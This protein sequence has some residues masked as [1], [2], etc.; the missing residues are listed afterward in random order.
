MQVIIYRP[1]KNAMQS[2]TAKT[3]QWK[4][5]FEQTAPQFVEPVMG[6]VGMRDTQQELSLMFDTEEAAIAYA[7]KHGYLYTIKQPK[8]RKIS[9]KNYAGN[10]ATNRLMPY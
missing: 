9:P 4:I 10:F 5:A 8:E 1:A 3:H 2:G 6:W 7:K